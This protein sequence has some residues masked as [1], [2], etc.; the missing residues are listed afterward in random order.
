MR[1]FIR[2]IIF[3]ITINSVFSQNNSN[4]FVKGGS[5]LMGTFLSK[6]KDERPIHRI[7][8]SDFYIGKYEVS[9]S[10]FA[11]FLNAKGNF[12]NQHYTWINLKGK[13]RNEKCRIFFQDSIYKVEKG[14]ENHPVL[15]VSWYGANAYCNWNGGRLPTEAEWE[16]AALGGSKSKKYVFSGSDIANKCAIFKDNSNEKIHNIATKKPNELGIYDM[17]GNLS[18]Y[19]SDWYSE[20]YYKKSTRNNP[21]GP[22]SGNYKVY[23]GGSF[24][25]EKQSL[26]IKNRK[27]IAPNENNITIGFRIVYDI[28]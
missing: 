6:S 13:W 1:I 16:Y 21:K 25:T 4:V 28:N 5:F 8:L 22:D 23:R 12:S 27:G 11:L 9:N 7:K 26:Y 3:F 19:C 24:Y 20:N 2:L 18:E 15:F 17:S 10:E 14:Y